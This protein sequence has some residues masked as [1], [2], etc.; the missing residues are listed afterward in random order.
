MHSGGIWS[1][2]YIVIDFMTL[3]RDMGGGGCKFRAVTRHRTKEIVPPTAF[4]FPMVDLEQSE[5]PELLDTDSDGELPSDLPPIAEGSFKPTA[6]GN[7]TPRVTQANTDDSDTDDGPDGASTWTLEEDSWEYNGSA[8]IRHHRQPRRIMVSP[9]KCDFPPP[10]PVHQIDVVRVTLTSLDTL[11]EKRIDD[12]W[13]GS[14]TDIRSLSDEWTGST[15]FNMIETT[16][17]PGFVRINGVEARKVKTFRPDEIL[18]EL[19]KGMSPKQRETAIAIY[20]ARK[21]RIDEARRMRRLVLTTSHAKQH[22]RREAKS[23]YKDNP[24]DSQPRET[25]SGGPVEPIAP[26]IPVH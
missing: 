25:A 18:P 1:G 21:P 3:L 10:V 5:A 8:V 13:D 23:Y 20:N 19:W 2:D 22:V 7:L 14:S 9:E 4:N 12:C 26:A 6:E 24:Y 17:R 15:T 16:G 11:D